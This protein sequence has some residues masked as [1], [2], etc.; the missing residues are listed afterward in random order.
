MLAQII[1]EAESLVT[2]RVALRCAR[3][4]AGSGCAGTVLLMSRRDRRC[5]SGGCRQGHTAVASR[6]GTRLSRASPG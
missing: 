5:W 1:H 2:W 6:R 3:V 4:R